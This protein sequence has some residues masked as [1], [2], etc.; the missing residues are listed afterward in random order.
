MA[1]WTVSSTSLKSGTEG[2]DG[3]IGLWTSYPDDSNYRLRIGSNFS[4]KKSGYMRCT[5][6]K[7]GNWNIN[8]NSI[9]TEQASLG[10]GVQTTV[11]LTNTGIT[12]VGYGSVSWARIIAVCTS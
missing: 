11:K 12:V 2:S 3:F 10:D 5:S 1:G 4:I 9:E 8:S 7:I 6:G